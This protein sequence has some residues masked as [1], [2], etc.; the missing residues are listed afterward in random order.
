M[1][2]KKPTTT[3][4]PVK[5]KP[6][7]IKKQEL[8][9]NKDLPVVEAVKALGVSP[10]ER[11]VKKTKE[12]KQEPVALPV[13]ETPSKLKRKSNIVAGSDEAKAWSEKM[14]LARE[15]KKAERLAQQ[16]QVVAN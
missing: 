5:T 15:K 12:P 16:T 10:R 9:E 4:Q 11:A 8:I 1:A 14:K 3:T 2:S 7:A 6:R 13:V